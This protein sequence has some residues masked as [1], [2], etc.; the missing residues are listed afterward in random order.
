MAKHKAESDE[1]KVEA[2]LNP[3]DFADQ[4]DYLVAKKAQEAEA[5]TE[6][7]KPEAQEE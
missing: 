3:A 4:S 6:K 1:S 5:K 2:K 7:V